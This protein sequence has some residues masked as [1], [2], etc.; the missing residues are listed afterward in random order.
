M[1]DSTSFQG[2]TLRSEPAIRPIRSATVRSW[3]CRKS[4]LTR[5]AKLMMPMKAPSATRNRIRKFRSLTA[6][7]TSRY[8]PS[9]SRMKE[10]EM[11]GRI[12]AQMAMAPL[13]TKNHQVSGVWVGTRPTIT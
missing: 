4:Q 11:P 8:F 9:R 10:P 12:M 6:A 2:Q 3:W 13:S 1:V 5:R 7:N